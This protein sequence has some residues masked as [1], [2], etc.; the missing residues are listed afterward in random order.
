MAAPPSPRRVLVLFAHPALQKSRANARLLDTLRDLEHVTVHDLYEV[1]PDFCID[2]VPEQR[3]LLEHEV[4][5]FQFPLYWYS[6]P[7]L[8][9]QWQDVVL[10]Y[11]WAYGPG[12]DRLHGKTALVA[13]TTGGPADS[14]GAGGYNRYRI[15]EL[16]RPLEQT[17]ALCG[18]RWLPPFV[19][20][21]AN[22]LSPATIETDYGRDYRDLLIALR[23]DALDLE[24]A[25]ALEHVN[26][27]GGPRPYPSHAEARHG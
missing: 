19:V 5:V 20:H 10:E 7:A 18:M 2:P 6:T 16:L 13:T 27:R 12:G 11:G 14:Y 26:P 23:D 8:L 17:V 24:A 21:G 22:R 15:T 1:W 25:R 4:V 3:L 9:K